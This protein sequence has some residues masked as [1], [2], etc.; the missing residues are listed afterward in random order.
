MAVTNQVFA[1][2]EDAATFSIVCV[3]DGLLGMSF[4][5]LA[6]SEQVGGGG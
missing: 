6:S 3:E 5:E 4:D 1:E 2:I